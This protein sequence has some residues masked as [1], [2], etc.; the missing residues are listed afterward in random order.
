[1]GSDLVILLSI[2]VLLIASALFSASETALTG[3][4]RARIHVLQQHGNRAAAVVERLWHRREHVIATLLIGNNTVNILASTLAASLFIGWFGDTGVIYAT[5]VMTVLVILFSEVLPKTYAL[6]QADRAALMAARPI[7]FATAVLSPVTRAVDAIVKTILRLAGVRVRVTASEHQERAEEELRGAIALHAGQE[8][9]QERAM[10]R[11]ILDLAQ[12]EVSEIMTPRRDV[13]AL[14]AGLPPGEIVQQV[15]DSPFTRFPLWRD[16]P[17]NIVG[18]LHAKRL[19]R[20]LHAAAGD[21]SKVDVLAVAQSP[22]FIPDTTDLLSQLE[23]F[24]QR[25]EHF[26]MV[27]NEYGDFL[28]VVTLEDILEEIV[29]DIADEHDVR[30][31]GVKQEPDGSFVVDGRVTLRDL[32]RQFDWRLPDA[33]ANTLAGLVLYEARIIP[34]V[35]QVFTFHGFRFEILGRQR[36]QITKLRVLPPAPQSEATAVSGDTIPPK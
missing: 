9:P 22:W 24:Q 20:A 28:G 16:N 31:E 7:A 26:A 21:Q 36:H 18:V 35:G 25:H 8:V 6:N 1:M 27:V 17:D 4:S 5:A 33:E 13:V 14:D 29:G 30:M 3:A 32:N 12:V 15:L 19:L 10:L 34:D 23:A 11:S 2:L